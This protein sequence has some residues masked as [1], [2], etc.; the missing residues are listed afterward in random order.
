MIGQAEEILC[1]FPEE[2]DEIMKTRI[3][4]AGFLLCTMFRPVYAAQDN[5]YPKD[6]P[7]GIATP[8]PANVTETYF[9]KL[10]DLGFNILFSSFPQVLSTQENLMI[11]DT[12]KTAGLKVF[13]QDSRMPLSILP[14]DAK[15]NLDAIVSD[16]S[17]QPALAGYVVAVSPAEPAFDGLAQVIKYLHQKDP[18]HPA[19]V[20]LMSG[21]STP[22]QLGID[23]YSEYIYHF[24]HAVNPE[25]MVTF[26]QPL[27]V[28]DMEDNLFQ[29]LHRTLNSVRNIGIP[30]W[31]IL[32]VSSSPGQSISSAL[33]LK[34]EALQR[35]VFNAHGLVFTSSN[36]ESLLP[37]F[38][39]N[40]SDSKGAAALPKVNIIKELQL[41]G[42]Y[43][44]YSVPVLAFENGNNV[45]QDME[46][47]PMSPVSF[48][49]RSRLTVGLFRADTHLYILMVNASLTTSATADA[50]FMI[51]DNK[52]QRLDAK[53]GRWIDMPIKK[54]FEGNMH[55][56]IELSPGEGIL[57]RW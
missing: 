32:Q 19:V 54:D 43:L 10:A 47:D 17:R 18:K 26:S 42:K 7:I 38:N 9:K 12:A 5:W 34:W 27:P 11:L 57:F 53:T 20:C 40:K 48:A 51:A 14:N 24:I 6:Y 4:L 1:R 21:D 55:Q 52:P 49:D 35:M 3:L 23:S 41:F 50:L 36:P 22:D 25:L 45:P 56:K 16:Y 13:I 29:D 8:S 2:A 28:G 39:N 37:Y 30:V 46:Q 31:Q 15:S 44:Q 33:E